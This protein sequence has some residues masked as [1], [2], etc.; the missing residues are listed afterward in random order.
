MG[1]C[2]LYPNFVGL[3]CFIAS[4]LIKG[5]KMGLILWALGNN[6]IWCIYDL[7]SKVYGSLIIHVVLTVFTLVGIFVYDR[8]T[9]RKEEKQ[10]DEQKQPT[11]D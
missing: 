1:D 7:V 11:E 6:G 2:I 8:K 3:F 5:K 9:A 4:F 10:E